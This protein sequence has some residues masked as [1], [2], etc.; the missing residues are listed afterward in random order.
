MKTLIDAGDAY[1]VQQPDP[2]AVDLAQRRLLAADGATVALDWS[3]G[4]PQLPDK[5]TI[6]QPLPG[7]LA[8]DY[9]ASSF[10]VY[11]HGEWCYLT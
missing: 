4:A 3:G 5:T 11:S 10:V 7:M 2:P 8:F 6:G 1:A 9:E